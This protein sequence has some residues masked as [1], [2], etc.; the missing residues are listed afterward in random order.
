MTSC[1]T[2]HTCPAL[3]S[4]PH[5]PL[6][7]STCTP[8][9]LYTPYSWINRVELSHCS[10]S[11]SAHC[12]NPAPCF[13]SLCPQGPGWME[14]GDPQPPPHQTTYSIPKGETPWLPLCLLTSHLCPASTHH[15]PGSTSS[16]ETF[17]SPRLTQGPYKLLGVHFLLSLAQY[18]SRRKRPGHSSL[19][20]LFQNS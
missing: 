8:K 15:L 12:Q 4:H 19:I 2:Q 3:A 5:D 6:A 13:C 9:S 20:T 10:P 11:V 7:L 16:P 14:K 18:Q 17:P 1:I